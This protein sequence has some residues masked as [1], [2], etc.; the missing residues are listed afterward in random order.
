MVACVGARRGQP[1]IGR[2]R[3]KRHRFRSGML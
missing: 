3:V 2:V 1:A